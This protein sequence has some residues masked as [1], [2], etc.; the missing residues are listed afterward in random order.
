M[1]PSS[2]RS[3]PNAIIK[4]EESFSKIVQLITASRYKVIQ[5]VNSGLIDLYWNIGQII[6]GKIEA[7]EW[8]DGVVDQLARYIS[9][10]HPG[11]RGFTRANL[12]R[13]RQFYETYRS[14]EIVAPLARQ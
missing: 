6:S 8:G 5:A 9:R 12:F 10:T 11:L 4:E 14:D 7:A 1:P 13:M 2:K 3:E